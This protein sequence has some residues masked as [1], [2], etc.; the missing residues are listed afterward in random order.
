MRGIIDSPWQGERW[1]LGKKRATTDSM[2]FAIPIE[3]F[4]PFTSHVRSILKREKTEPTQLFIAQ[5][6]AFEK[7]DIVQ[8]NIMLGR[9]TPRGVFAYGEVALKAANIIYTDFS[10]NHSSH[11]PTTSSTQLRNTNAK[12]LKSVRLTF[13]I[14]WP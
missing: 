9:Q 13:G 7:A 10:P 11:V 12:Y 6:L 2:F 8:E 5:V 1:L 4:S 3:V 14:N